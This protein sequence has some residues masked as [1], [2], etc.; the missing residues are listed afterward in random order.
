[1]SFDLLGPTPDSGIEKWQIAHPD[2]SKKLQTGT[3]Y[4]LVTWYK[5]HLAYISPSKYIVIG[6]IMNND[7]SN[8]KMSI[9]QPYIVGL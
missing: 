6:D 4:I 5:G 3:C 2:F 1:M 8:T 7:Y 9:S